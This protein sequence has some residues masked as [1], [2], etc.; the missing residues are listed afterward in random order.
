MKQMTDRPHHLGSA[1]GRQNAEFMAAQFRSWGYDTEIEQFD[2]LFPTPKAR[3]LEMIAPERYV[4]RLEEPPLAQDSTSGIARQEQLPLFNAYSIDGD[5]TGDLVYVNY[6]IP[7][8]YE[9]LEERGVD[10]KGKIVIARC[11]QCGLTESHP[12]KRDQQEEPLII[13]KSRTHSS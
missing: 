2:V 10:V 12:I 1:K 13:R 7:K 9:V 6:G 5:V 11:P 8:D 4:A 3:V